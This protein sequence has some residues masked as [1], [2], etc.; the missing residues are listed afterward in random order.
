MATALISD[1]PTLADVMKSIGPNGQPFIGLAETLTQSTPLL[2]DATWQQCN[3][4]T[5]HV[6][7]SR[8]AL[9]SVG[10][11]KYN[12]GVAASKSKEDTIE[13][14]C[15]MLE[16]R[17]QIDEKMVRLNGGAAYRAKMDEAFVQSFK[18]ELETG[19]FYHSTND[20]PHKFHGLAPRFAATTDAYGKQIILQD[21][22]ASG[23]DQT[24]VWIVCWSPS[25]V[26]AIY[27]E[28]S[29]AG[30]RRD[31]R[32]VVDVYDEA[33]NMYRAYVTYWNW[34]VGLCVQDARY[35][36]RIGN[37]DTSALAKTGRALIDAMVDGIEQ[38]QDTDTGR[39][40]IYCNRKVQTYL[41]HQ[42]NDGTKNSTLTY[43]NVAG[44][45]V[46]SIDGIP[47]RRTD[48]LLN[49]GAVLV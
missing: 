38:L 48:A 14:S 9:P 24:D 25:T 42:S 29:A 4:K 20:A 16:G 45:R 43:E 11:R 7:L 5:G 27:P 40:A 1:N 26:Y 19:F 34:D 8:T 2:M 33:D 10:W 49:T 22:G 36:V 28:G 18:H 41:R 17:S 32:G 44:R 15:G 39:C 46:V 35:V 21:S 6:F 3:K 47:V 37:V 30:L 13:E 23:S 31:D 12:E